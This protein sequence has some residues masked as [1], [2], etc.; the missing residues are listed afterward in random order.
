MNGRPINE[1]IRFIGACNP[2]REREETE[3]DNG[4]KMEKI[5]EGKEKMAYL[6]NLLPNSMLYYI[7]YFKSLENDDVKKYIECIVGEEFPPGEEE[8]NKE[9]ENI[10]T[11]YEILPKIDDKVDKDDK[12]SEK[13]IFRDTAIYAIYQSHTHVRKK[14]W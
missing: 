1:K 2:Y 13:S 4:L 11:K 6:V 5:N 14:K 8:K 12:R 7:F 9:Q 3:T 10:E